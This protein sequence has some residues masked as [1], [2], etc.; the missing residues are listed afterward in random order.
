MRINM[1]YKELLIM[2]IWGKRPAFT[3][4]ANC[5]VLHIPT[6]EI[7]EVMSASSDFDYT[8]KIKRN[9]QF[10]R[11]HISEIEAYLTQESFDNITNGFDEFMM[12]K[13]YQEEMED[14]RC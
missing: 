8:L 2:A 9:G 4:C 13:A 10:I 6:A 5:D 12:H 7:V 1:T 14:R 11:G 3:L